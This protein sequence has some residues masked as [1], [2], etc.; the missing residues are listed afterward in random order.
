MDKQTPVQTGPLQSLLQKTAAIVAV[1]MVVLN[2]SIGEVLAAS[3]WNP[4]LLVNTEA[5]NVIDGTDAA[6]PTIDLRFGQTIAEKISYNRSTQNF[7]FSRGLAVAGGITA[8]GSLIVRAHMSG[9][10]LQVDRTL[11]VSG[12]VLIEGNLTGATISGFGLKSCTGSNK[13]LWNTATGKFECG[14]DLTGGGGSSPE[15]GT[16]AF[17]GGVLRLGDG[18]YLRTAGGTMT[19]NL[20]VRAAVS[21]TTLRIGAGGGDVHGPFSVSGALRTDGD[22]SINDDRSAGDATLT[23]GNATANQT[24]KYL[25]GTAQKFQFSRNVSV[26]GSV[27]GAVLR[28]DNELQS[29]GSLLVEGTMSGAT[30]EGANL[31]DCDTAATSK[32]LWDATTKKFSCGTDQA[33]GGGSNPAWAG[34]LHGAMADGNSIYIARSMEILNTVAGPTPTNITASLARC[35]SYRSAYAITVNRLRLLGVGATTNLYKFAVYPRGTGAA[36]LWESGTVTSAANTWLSISAN[37]PFTV[38]ANTDYWFCVT[39]ANTGTTAGFRS[40]PAPINTT[41][42]NADNSPLGARAMGLPVYVQF[43]VTAGAFPATLPAVAAA[44]YAGGTTGSVPFAFFDNTS[45]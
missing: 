42:Y 4:T 37:M 18:R 8:T 43:A 21:G 13:L 16:T 22:L 7:Q 38:A 25:N 24:L 6:A 35:V 14:T 15:I 41:Q 2:H 34:L 26:L 23:F 31:R 10:S 19:G 27:S 36:R 32:L 29:S 33:G 30:I 39:V 5:F 3:S 9:S 20:I 28:A 17:S 11:S 1:F 44:A 40:P 12:S 45:P